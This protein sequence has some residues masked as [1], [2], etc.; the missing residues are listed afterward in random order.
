MGQRFPKKKN[1]NNDQKYKPNRNVYF[2]VS[3]SKFWKKPIHKTIKKLRDRYGL[4]WLRVRMAHKRHQ[5]IREIFQ[6]DLSNKLAEGLESIDFKNRSCN[7]NKASLVHGQC[8]YKGD[9]RR[10]C[11]IYDAKCRICQESYVGNTQNYYKK[12]FN[13]HFADVQKK[14]ILGEKSDSFANHFARHFSKKPSPSELREMIDFS[15]IWQGNAIQLSKTFG[16][17]SYKLCMMERLTILDRC[18]KN[19]SK[20]INKC[21][22]IFGSCRHK[23]C[24]HRFTKSTDDAEKVEKKYLQIETELDKKSE[25]NFCKWITPVPL[26][27]IDTNSRT[28]KFSFS[29]FQSTKNR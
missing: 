22:E 6:A 25:E 24:F 16:K 15:V 29:K 23:P 26:S 19:K 9:C 21:S 17:S 11:I 3:F 13:G 28:K 7:C 18:R 8:P 10:A 1:E 12:R 2:T 4:K 14:V 20:M 5:N 27:T